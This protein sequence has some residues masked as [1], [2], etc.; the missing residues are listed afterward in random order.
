MRSNASISTRL[1]LQNFDKVVSL[2]SVDLDA[3]IKIKDLR[4]RR[5][6][7]RETSRE[8]IKALKAHKHL[9][10]TPFVNLR[11]RLSIGRHKFK[12]APS[13]QDALDACEDYFPSRGNIPV[14]VCDFGEG[15]GNSFL[16][17]LGKLDTFWSRKPD[18]VKVR[19]MHVPIGRGLLHST[20][21]DL[22]MASGECG[23][24]FR[25]AGSSDW[26]YPR[27]ETFS[28]QSKAGYQ[29]KLE[30]LDIL[31]NAKF[32]ESDIGK[33]TFENLDD[34]LQSDLEWRAMHLRTKL[35]FWDMVKSDFPGLLSEQISL[36]QQ[37]PLD[38]QKQR[39]TILSEQALTDHSQY[40]EALLTVNSLRSY[41]KS[42]GLS[43][44]YLALQ[45]QPLT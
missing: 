1:I 23:R 32:V 33:K 19:W 44:Y 2:G 38:A 45:L 4:R 40:A 22:Y 21:Q 39:D 5:A 25:H 15:K 17:T 7:R 10:Q 3:S 9:T 24:S 34:A 30:A 13:H 41:H 16:T 11:N 35:S 6:E 18:W 43:A 8:T 14:R 36:G 31:S 28:L 26:P 29:E 20:I 27:M 42:D 12:F 37:G